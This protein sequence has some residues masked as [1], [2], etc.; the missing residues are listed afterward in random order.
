VSLAGRMTAEESWPADKVE[1]TQ[2]F[3]GAL[4][5]KATVTVVAF[6][7]APVALVQR[8]FSFYGTRVT[9]LGSAHEYL[10]SKQ[11]TT[12][13]CLLLPPASG[14]E[15]LGPA[16]SSGK[17]IEVTGVPITTFW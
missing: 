8:L 7:S 13:T 14:Y 2:V 1:L 10:A 16:T 12:N 15:R 6:E 4:D 11:A 5:A 17:C 9:G 3:D